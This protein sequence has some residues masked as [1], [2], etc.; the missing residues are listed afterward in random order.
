MTITRS[1]ISGLGLLFAALGIGFWIAPGP[2]ATLLQLEAAGASALAALRPDI[3]GLFLGLAVLCLTGAIAKRRSLVLA[4]GIVVMT[5]ATGRAIN[6]IG[7]TR[8]AMQLVL[9]AIE[10]IA[11][12]VLLRVGRRDPVEARAHSHVTRRRLV[13]VGGAI[14]AAIGVLAVILLDSRIE[15][16]IFE[17]VAAQVT[18]NDNAQLLGDDA[19]RIGICGSSAPLPSATRAKA[20]VAV[21]AGGQFY[22]VDVGPES[23]ENVVMWGIPLASVGGV[24]LTHFHS[25]HIGDLGELNLQTWAAGRP[26]TLSVYGGPGVEQVVDGFNIAY[27]H[28]QGYRTAHHTEKLMAPST[29]AM[30]PRPIAMDGSR[31]S[32]KNRTSVFLEDGGLKITAIEVDH[33]P[34]APAYAYRFDYKGRSVLITGDLKFQES[35]ATPARDVDVLISEAIAVQM[36]RALGAGARNAGRERTAAIMHDIEDYHITP[37][38]AAQVANAANA[39]LLVLYHLLPAPDGVLPRRLFAQG[40]DQARHGEWTLADDGSLYTL[41]IGS[42]AVQIGRVGSSE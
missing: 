34:V 22:L 42:K 26:T 7:G 27:R 14:A 30:V 32:G 28:D 10:V 39:Q 33:T 13:V 41:P 40:L 12:V 19:L 4:A 18:A 37:E 11:A 25:D 21:F 2:V 38:Q 5:V 29:W 31:E 23:V 20:C 36:T 6:M 17:R 8:S 24:M 16:R 35:L 1:V 3:G 9:F 15:S